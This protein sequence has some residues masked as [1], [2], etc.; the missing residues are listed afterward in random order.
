MFQMFLQ[1]RIIQFGEGVL[2]I[3][4]MGLAQVELESNPMRLSRI[5]LESGARAY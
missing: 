2:A 3:V 1:V 4:L 5:L